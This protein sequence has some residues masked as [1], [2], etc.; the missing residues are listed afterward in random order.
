MLEIKII[1]H[2]MKFRYESSNNDMYPM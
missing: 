1:Q 2:Q